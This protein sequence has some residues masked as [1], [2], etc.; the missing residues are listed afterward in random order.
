MSVQLSNDDYRRAIAAWEQQ[1]QATSSE[2]GVVGDKHGEQV[3]LEAVAR[4]EFSHGLRE[5]AHGEFGP[6][7]YEWLQQLAAARAR[8]REA[9]ATLSGAASVISQH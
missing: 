3:Y 2:L 8:Q 7:A 9:A 1:V 6:R 4:G 5:M